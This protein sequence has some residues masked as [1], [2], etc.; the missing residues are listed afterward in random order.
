MRVLAPR[1]HA[2][3]EYIPRRRFISEI[4]SVVIG[5]ETLRV[6]R[7]LTPRKCQKER[8]ILV[9]TCT[10]PPATAASGGS[11]GRCGCRAFAGRPGAST[12]PRRAWRTS[13]PGSVPLAPGSRPK[14]PPKG[15]VL[16]YNGTGYDGEKTKG[17]YS[18]Q[19]VVSERFAL[20]IQ[21]SPGAWCTD[22]PR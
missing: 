5:S 13:V 1:I 4:P 7:F 19:I 11:R 22:R 3:G 20:R 15:A 12:S 6:R 21:L 18:Q 8:Q 10:S 16:T 14:Q 2:G 9:S 17:G